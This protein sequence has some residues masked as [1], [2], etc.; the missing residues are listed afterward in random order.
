[1]QHD[2]E[3]LYPNKIKTA[4]VT[5]TSLDIVRKIATFINIDD[6]F[7]T[8]ITSSDVSHPK[9][10]PEPYFAMMKK[11]N[12]LPIN[13]I[14]IEDSLHGLRAGLSAGAHVIAIT[15]SVPNKDL[16]IAHRIV[17]HLDEITNYMLE[18]LLQ[19]SV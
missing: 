17:S 19:E 8:I 1:M 16:S 3:N 11:L 2:F 4:L 14:I 9:P 5:N 6:Y 13:S 12:V 15:G 18:E 10:H 7:S